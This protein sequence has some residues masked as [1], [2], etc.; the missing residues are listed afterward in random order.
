MDNIGIAQFDQNAFNNFVLEHN[1]IGF[2]DKAIKLK[3]GRLSHFYVNW[4]KVTKDAFRTEQLA[5][6]IISYV[7]DNLQPIPDCIIG[8]PEGATKSAE[9]AQYLWA[10]ESVNYGP[11][12]HPLPMM[13]AKPKEH[14]DP[15]D[16]YYVGAPR[17]RTVILEDVTTT[18]DSLLQAIDR[19]LETDGVELIA[20]IG[21]TN[22]ME[23]RDD[24]RSVERAVAERNVAYFAMSNA[25]ELLPEAYKRLQPDDDIARAVEEEFEKYGEQPL[26]LR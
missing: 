5:K 25:L 11:G 1:A 7:G 20:A 6:F 23:K 8:V 3:S 18:G 16:K 26:K 12:S 24:G 19:L 10:R 14:G 4:R 21:I 2:F 15:K 13:R 17:G 22:R 9:L